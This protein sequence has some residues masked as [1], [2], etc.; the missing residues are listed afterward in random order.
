[1]V[2]LAGTAFLVYQV[3]N[4]INYFQSEPTIQTTSTVYPSEVPFPAVII[5]NQNSIKYV[6][7]MTDRVA[8]NNNSL[9]KYNIN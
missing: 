1:M 9:M 8:V 5:C 3:H 4:T 2:L 7:C 6:S